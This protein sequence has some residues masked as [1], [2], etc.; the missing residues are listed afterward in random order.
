[1]PGLCFLVY[2]PSYSVKDI[3][4]WF[5]VFTS[6]RYQIELWNMLLECFIRLVAQNVSRE[7]SLHGRLQSKYG[8][9][10]TV[11]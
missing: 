2:G 4:G 7:K 11:L 10:N 6:V 9:A 8:N 3:S 5:P 1:M